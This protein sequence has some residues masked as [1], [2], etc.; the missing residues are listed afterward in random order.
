MCLYES[1][2]V[3]SSAIVLVIVV[4]GL[5]A[6]V[7]CLM[8]ARLCVSAGRDCSYCCRCGLRESVHRISSPTPP[9]T[10]CSSSFHVNINAGHLNQCLWSGNCC[11]ASRGDAP[12]LAR[13][14]RHV[15]CYAVSCVPLSPQL[16]QEQLLKPEEVELHLIRMLS[17]QQGRLAV[18]DDLAPIISSF[19]A[20]LDNADMCMTFC[21]GVTAD[22]V[23]CSESTRSKPREIPTQLTLEFPHVSVFA[24]DF[25]LT[26]LLTSAR[27]HGGWSRLVDASITAMKLL[28]GQ[29]KGLV[30]SLV[31]EVIPAPHTLTLSLTVPVEL[32]EP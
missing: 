17:A 14:Q 16:T 28:C 29:R 10:K 18:E 20:F 5:S 7:H 6:E 31:L 24:R 12:P 11:R 27:R 21:D 23:K 32:A 26:C 15:S 8:Q 22:A 1:L 4:C 2:C 19:P 25:V 30:H 13:V 9:A 3:C